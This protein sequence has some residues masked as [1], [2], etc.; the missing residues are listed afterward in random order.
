MAIHASFAK[1]LPGLVLL[2]AGCAAGPDF[3]RP[4]SEAAPLELP[5]RVG[6][7]G[8]AQTLRA[9][10]DVPAQW[11]QLFRSP[12]LDGLVRQALADSPTLAQARAKLAQAREAVNAEAGAR[13][14]PAVDASL[15]GVRQRV[16]P[17]SMG[18]AVPQPPPFT[19]YNASISVAYTL[20]AWGGER[21]AVEGYAAEA[22]RAAYEW[23]A[24]RMTLAANVVTTAI[25]QA[26]QRETLQAATALAEAQR[27]Q[28]RIVRK[29][30]DAGAVS[31]R[32][33]RAQAALAAQTEAQ[34]PALRQ[35]LARSTHQLAVYL[36]RD[37]A[38]LPDTGLTLAGLAL[39]AE[40]PVSVPS[41]LARQR[42]DILAAEAAWHRA[43]ADVGVAT[44]NLYPRLTLSAGFG[45]QR[46]HAG[47]LGNG[48]NI[49]NLGLGLAQPL[50]RGGELRARKRGAEAAYEAAAAAYR[51]TVL[52]GWR[53]VADSLRA[54]EHDAQALTRRRE[55]EA[56]TEAV[57]A[58]ASR[59]YREG[60]ISQLALLDAQRQ[61]L[62][63]RRDR[64][65]ALT[66]RYTDTAALM[67]ALGGGWW[68]EAPAEP[69]V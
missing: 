60:G 63:A 23:Q 50:W 6:Q 48:V 52:Q 37:P 14:L 22:E 55:A 54:L 42:P 7:D 15:S 58:T 25:R 61:L 32:E 57:Y 39:P 27:E 29:R 47:D 68:N 44:A 26:G 62:A 66:S 31:E 49:W 34:L 28:L 41:A 10:A 17:S 45:T 4:V 64:I 18:I 12:V 16:D 24:A 5:A 2:L 56:Q 67:H 69:G 36:G 9:G 8:D 33:W 43:A 40:V 46:T 20:D 1:Y 13:L 19:L 30:L 65:E 38:S 51:D 3:Q 21:R 53:Q 11:W 35:A 59:Q